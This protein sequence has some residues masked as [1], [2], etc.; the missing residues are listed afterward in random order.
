MRLEFIIIQIIGVFIESVIT[1][2]FFESTMSQN[3]CNRKFGNK[4][5]YNL[6]YNKF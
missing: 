2:Q 4:Y 3:K 5:T 1:Y 6:Y